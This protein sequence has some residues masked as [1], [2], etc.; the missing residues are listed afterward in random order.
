MA[1]Q[2][3]LSLCLEQVHIDLFLVWHIRRPTIVRS[4]N[5]PCDLN[6]RFKQVWK[7]TT[8]YFLQEK[9]QAR[10]IKKKFLE[11]ASHQSPT[12]IIHHKLFLMNPLTSSTECQLSDE[13]VGHMK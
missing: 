6:R 4:V 13:I 11:S 9:A 1:S 10:S 5:I 2:F 8:K 3:I 7:A 12:L